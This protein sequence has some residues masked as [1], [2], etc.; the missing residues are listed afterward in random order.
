MLV[1]DLRARLEQSHAELAENESCLA[2]LVDAKAEASKA[3]REAFAR[4]KDDFEWRTME[5]DRLTVL[6]EALS[7]ELVNEGGAQA[8]AAFRESYKR[9]RVANDE[10]AKR[11]ANELS[12]INNQV[13]ALLR[14]IATAALED[15]KINAALPPD[16]AP[17]VSAHVLAR[18][19]P[20]RPREVVS[21]KRLVSWVRSDNGAIVGDPDAVEDIGNGRGIIQR[22]EPL[23]AIRCHKALF[24]QISFHPAEDPVRPRP[25]WHMR[26][27]DA[28]GPG[29]I[30][31]GTELTHPSHVLAALDRVA[32]VS[33]PRDRPIETEIR[34]VRGES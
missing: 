33:E 10:L 17:L 26:L 15:A 18:A 25:F 11:I 19:R 29:T 31:D 24:E 1:S 9:R 21:C 32:Q 30:F 12:E 22:M 5:K 20:G 7:Q 8:D 28:D 2:A 23:P 34:P 13:L 6:V 14:E 4:W 3:G 16:L 27:V